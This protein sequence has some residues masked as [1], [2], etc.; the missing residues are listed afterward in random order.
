MKNLLSKDNNIK[1]PFSY[2]KK[3]DKDIYLNIFKV[4]IYVNKKQMNYLF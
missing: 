1:L 2:I 3:V 4:F